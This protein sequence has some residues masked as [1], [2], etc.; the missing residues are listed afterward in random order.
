MKEIF[1]LPATPP[2][3][4]EPVSDS[5]VVAEDDPIFLRIL[6]TW[7][8]KWNYQV[9]AVNNGV[10]AWEVLQKQDAPRMA[11]LDWMM[12]GM[13]GLEVC[14]KIRAREHGPYCYVLL[15]T[16]TDAREDVG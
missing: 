16:A 3:Q 14:K 9:T 1:G 5:V 10:E 13:D 11:V 15:L 6:Q 2:A 12:P 4:P 7:F 8:R